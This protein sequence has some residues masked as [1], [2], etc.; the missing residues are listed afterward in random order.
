[1]SRADRALN[2]F[3]DWFASRGGVWQTAI[4]LLVV[5]LAERIWSHADPSGFWLL[6]WCTVYS[7]VT[8]PIL[9]YCN[10]LA[11]EKADRDTRAI[12]SEEDQILDI[13]SPH[14]TVNVDSADTTVVQS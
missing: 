1:V 11:A 5:V 3:A 6:Y 2:W 13:V 10:R 4:A 8:Q 7:A 14:V 12:K 9:A